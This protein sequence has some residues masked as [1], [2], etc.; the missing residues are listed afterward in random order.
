MQEAA[1]LRLHVHLLRALLEVADQDHLLEDRER[2][3]ACR[4]AWAASSRR[5]RS[6]CR[7]ALLLLPPA[8][9][10]VPTPNPGDIPPYRQTGSGHETCGPSS[11]R[12]SPQKTFVARP[13]RVGTPHPALRPPRSVAARNASFTARVSTAGQHRLRVQLASCGREQD[14]VGS[15]RSRPPR[16]PGGS[17]RA[18]RPPRGRSA[19]AYVAARIAN[20][21]LP[22]HG[23]GHRSGG[24][25]RSARA[26]RPPP[27]RRALVRL[28]PGAPVE[29][30]EEGTEQDRL[31]HGR[32]RSTALIRSAAS[33]E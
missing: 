23:S 22:G 32:L 16:M 3:L 13:S 6:L 7:D 29:V 1:D 11:S 4:E 33:Y 14:V 21:M 25:P 15:L 18:R 27:C 28:G 9:L 2:G 19:R 31:P 26:A 20:S 12:S 5:R 24:S 8:S 30:L 10:S 17:R